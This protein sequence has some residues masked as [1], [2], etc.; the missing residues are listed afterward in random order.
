MTSK[1]LYQKLLEVKKAIPFLKKEAQGYKY[2]YVD[3]E[4]VLSTINPLL[5]EQGIL[6]LSSVK[7]KRIEKVTV[8]DKSG[9]HEEILYLLDMVFTW[10]D[11]FD[12]QKIEI[13]WVTSGMNGHEKGLGSALTYA[14]RYF[15]LKFFNIATGKEDPDARQEDYKASVNTPI[16]QRNDTPDDLI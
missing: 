12:G 1:T 9:P 15:L 6:L 14:E 16:I 13:P 2:S 5:N 8:T 11:T 10:V 3:P 4:T 7:D